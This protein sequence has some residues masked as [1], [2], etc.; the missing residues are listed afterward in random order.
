MRFV[1]A[2]GTLFQYPYLFPLSENLMSSY[3]GMKFIDLLYKKKG[4]LRYWITKLGE[5]AKTQIG[6]GC[7]H[8]KFIQMPSQPLFFAKKD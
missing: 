4:L 5:R 6:N 2:V 7:N 8:S 3:L 1:S